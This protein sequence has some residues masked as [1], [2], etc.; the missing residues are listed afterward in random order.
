DVRLVGVLTGQD[1]PVVAGL[2]AGAVERLGDA[3][4]ERVVRGEDDVDLLATPVERVETR[5]H[6]GLSGLGLPALDADRGPLVV[7][8]RSLARRRDELARVDVG[9]E[10]VPRTREEELRVVVVG[11]TGE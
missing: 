9:L 11:R 1:R 4:R 8:L 2:V 3:E 6:L 5:L 10:D 7:A